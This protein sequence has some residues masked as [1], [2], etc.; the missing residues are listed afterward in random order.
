MLEPREYF[1]REEVV[2]IVRA[3]CSPSCTEAEADHLLIAW[4][5][6]SRNGL[7]AQRFAFSEH[8]TIEPVVT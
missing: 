4:E 1:E 6:E 8:G 3:L 2:R 5:R 7:L